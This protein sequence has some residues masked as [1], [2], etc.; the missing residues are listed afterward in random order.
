MILGATL[1]DNLI[2]LHDHKLPNHK[3]PNFNYGETTKWSH[4]KQ[5][6]PK[7]QDGRRSSSCSAVNS[8]A[9]EHDDLTADVIKNVSKMQ[10]P[11]INMYT[12]NIQRL[13]N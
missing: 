12:N 6:I 2:A 9:T 5:F 3:L 1:E 8:W 4:Y 11:A 13:Y 7:L 10:E